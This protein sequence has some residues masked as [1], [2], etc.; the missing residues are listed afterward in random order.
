MNRK[1]AGICLAGDVTLFVSLVA[2]G[3]PAW[4]LITLGA[5][6]VPVLIVALLPERREPS[7]SSLS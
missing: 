6:A 2:T 7:T 3:A 5:L 4:A 1:T